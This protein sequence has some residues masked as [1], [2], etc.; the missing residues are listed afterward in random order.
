MSPERWESGEELQMPEAM[1]DQI[2]LPYENIAETLRHFGASLA[3]VAGPTRCKGRSRGHG[4]D[5]D[6]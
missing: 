6:D 2:S 3:D 4:T 1:E 5:G